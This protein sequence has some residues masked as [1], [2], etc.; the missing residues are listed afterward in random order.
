MWECILTTAVVLLGLPW[1]AVDCVWQCLLGKIAFL[2]GVPSMVLEDVV[3]IEEAEDKD[4]ALLCWFFLFSSAL[5]THMLMKPLVLLSVLR[6][7]L[8][9]KFPIQFIVKYVLV[10][11]EQISKREARWK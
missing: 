4:S 7:K 1:C 9:L 8:M 3:M 10:A 6:A 11:A 5:V 2:T